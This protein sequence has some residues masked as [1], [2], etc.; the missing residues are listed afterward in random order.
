MLCYIKSAFNFEV[1]SLSPLACLSPLSWSHPGFWHTVYVV[2]KPLHERK[3]TLAQVEDHSDRHGV[4]AVSVDITH[5]HHLYILAVLLPNLYFFLAVQQVLIV[6]Y[7]FDQD[8]MAVWNIVAWIED[9]LILFAQLLDVRVFLFCESFYQLLI[10]YGHGQ[11]NG[12]DVEN[13]Y[14]DHQFVLE[15][16]ENTVEEEWQNLLAGN[17]LYKKG[18]TPKARMAKRQ[19]YRPE[20][21]NLRMFGDSR[22]SSPS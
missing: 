4:P 21:Y 18:T 17:K 5:V 6:L 22:T 8:G 7:F 11:R 16:N 15:S 9:G 19:L 2:D 20:A 3:E 1:Q 10:Y 13:G 12:V 14:L